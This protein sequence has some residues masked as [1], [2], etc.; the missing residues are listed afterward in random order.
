MFAHILPNVLPALFVQV[1]FVL[2]TAVLAEASLSYL[3]LGATPPNSSWGSM[4]SEAADRLDRPHLLWPAGTL[5]SLTVLAFALVG[6]GLRD[7]IR[8]NRGGN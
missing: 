2:G 3:G 1:T 6:D 7:A 4:L 8:V 5:L